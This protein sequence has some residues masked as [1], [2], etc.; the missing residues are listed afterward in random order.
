MILG[1][2]GFLSNRLRLCIPE[3]STLFVH[4]NILAVSIG[5]EFIIYLF[6]LAFSI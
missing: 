6:F 3:V 5:F 1:S 2:I 4:N